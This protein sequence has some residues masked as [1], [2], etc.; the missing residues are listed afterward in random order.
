MTFRASG[1]LPAGRTG[2]EVDP[3][4]PRRVDKQKGR[5]ATAP[6]TL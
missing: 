2:S 4:H 5:L 6:K 1:F 3:L